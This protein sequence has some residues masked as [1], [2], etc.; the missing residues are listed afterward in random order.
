MS[1]D[2]N[3]GIGTTIPP[4]QLPGGLTIN[5]DSAGGARRMPTIKSEKPK[6]KYTNVMEIPSWKLESPKM[7]EPA[8]PKPEGPIFDIKTKL[9]GLQGKV[10]GAQFEM[11]IKATLKGIRENDHGIRYEIEVNSVA[12]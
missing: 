4:V 6:H 3:T 9:P 5:G 12:L 1:I 11:S 8:S 10:V 2:R 7:A